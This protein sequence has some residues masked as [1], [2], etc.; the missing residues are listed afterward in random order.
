MPNRSFPPRNYQFVTE[1]L[2]VCYRVEGRWIMVKLEGEVLEF[3]S[4]EVR[5]IVVSIEK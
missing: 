4:S 5:E 3:G 1:K 2:P